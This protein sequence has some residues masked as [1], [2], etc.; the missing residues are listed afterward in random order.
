MT[1]TVYKEALERLRSYNLPEAI[2]L[3]KTGAIPVWETTDTGLI[4]K[5]DNKL[6]DRAISVQRAYS[7][8][9][10]LILKIFEEEIGYYYIFA[11]VSARP[12]LWPNQRDENRFYENG[13][14]SCFQIVGPA[15]F[16]KKRRFTQSELIAGRIL[17]N[18][19][20]SIVSASASFN[21]HYKATKEGKY[22]D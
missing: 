4:C 8:Y 15:Y 18:N 17:V 21:R 11:S 19:R 3:F 10:F 16:P 14:G 13:S 6:S 2:K 5:A 22:D 7:E 12:G 20:I 9:P 1:P